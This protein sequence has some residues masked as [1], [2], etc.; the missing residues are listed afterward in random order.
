MLENN[1]DVNLSGQ[2]IAEELK[3]TRTAVWK[4]INALK[5]D[6]YEVVTVPHRG[7]QLSMRSDRLSIQGIAPYLHSPDTARLIE[8]YRTLESTNKTAK[9]MAVAGRKEDAVIIADSQTGGRGRFGRAFHSPADKGLYISF[10]LRPEKLPIRKVTWITAIAALAVCD[11]VK[12]V[13]GQDASIKW[14]ND[15]MIGGR[16]VCGILTEAITDM[17]SGSIERIV[18]GIGINI[19]S[20]GFPPELERI[21]GGLFHSTPPG[22]AR[23]R[24]AASL[25]NTFCS[26]ELWP[27]ERSLYRDY[28]ARLM[29]L[30]R[31][32]LVHTPKESYCARAVDLDEDYHLMVETPE[33]ERIALSSGEVSIRM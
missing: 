18:V 4:A 28:K 33:G 31:E 6:G 25:I 23:C 26:P 7:Y 22:S 16:K 24:L 11:A 10:L 29:L 12:L 27:D 17:E 2:W 20:E 5:A 32:V 30:G 3:L 9:E 15:V 21:A 19:V 14:V 13:S 8:V 1:R